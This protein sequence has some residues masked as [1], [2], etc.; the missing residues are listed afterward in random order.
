MTSEYTLQTNLS[1]LVS[2]GF[3]DCLEFIRHTSELT[4]GKGR[5]DPTKRSE[6]RSRHR[7][8]STL[9][10]KPTVTSKRHTRSKTGQQGNRSTNTESRMLDCTNLSVHNCSHLSEPALSDTLHNAPG[11]NGQRS[12]IPLELDFLLGTSFRLTRRPSGL[13]VCFHLLT[14]CLHLSE[15][16]GS[17]PRTTPEL[18]RPRSRSTSH[19]RLDRSWGPD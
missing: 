9:R 8:S 5:T 10:E 16:S 2:E 14:Y 7:S 19:L 15:R 1:D 11:K 13:H 4:S 3:T 17:R 6:L 12:R 18:I